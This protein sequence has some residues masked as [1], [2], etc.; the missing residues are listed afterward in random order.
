MD[1]RECL[2]KVKKI[3]KGLHWFK[4]GTGALAVRSEGQPLAGNEQSLPAAELL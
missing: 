3:D 1:I 4:A 2:D